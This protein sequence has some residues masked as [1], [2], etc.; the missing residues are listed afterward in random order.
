MATIK[1]KAGE[2][3][4]IIR[5]FSSSIVAT[6]KFSAD[7]VDSCDDLSGNVEVKGSRWLFPKPAET[8]KLGRQNSVN[9][10]M[11]DTFYSIYVVPDVDVYIT[12]PKFGIRSLW[13]YTALVVLIFVFAAGFLVFTGR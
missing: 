9:K 12:L 10:G 4:R 13:I 2:R 5:R 6:Y 11:W 8:Q 3:A 1:I 7:P